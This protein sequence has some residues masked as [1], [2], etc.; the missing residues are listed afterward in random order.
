MK[1]AML[2]LMTVFVL[3]A[4]AKAPAYNESDLD[5]AVTAVKDEYGELYGPAQAI[6]AEQLE[7]VMGIDPEWVSDFVAEGPLMSLSVDTFIA[8]LVDGDHVEEVKEALE[9]YK[10]YLETEAFQYPMNMAKVK[11]SE[12]V[13]KGNLVFFVLLGDYDD[14]EEATDDERLSFAK[15]EVKRAIDAID[16]ALK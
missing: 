5:T 15:D 1:K 12:V 10:L 6:S 11:A 16:A 7:E 4:C 13:V 2:V 9:A 8:V 3:G 14:R